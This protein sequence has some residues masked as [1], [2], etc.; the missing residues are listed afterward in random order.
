MNKDANMINGPEA[1]ET[2]DFVN[3]LDIFIENKWMIA[4]VTAIF[5][6]FGATYALVATPIY[7]T[8]ILVQVED[9]P[10]ASAAKSLL[11]NVSSLF[12]VKSS[13]AAEG[14]ILN[15]RLVV[16]R[17]VENLRLYIEAYPRRFPIL[18]TWIASRNS[19]LQHPGVFGIGGFAWGQESIDVTVFD[20]PPKLEGKKFRLKVVDPMHF[21]L[22]GD[23]LTRDFKGTVG[24]YERTES[25]DGPIVLQVKTLNGNA[26]TE[27]ELIRKSKFKTI[28]DFRK[29]LD[30]QER[31]K[32]SGVLIATLQGPD[33]VA[34]STQLNEIGHQ[35]VRQ[36]VERKSEEAAQSLEFL[37][38][39]LPAIKIRLENAQ[40]RYTQMRDRRGSV[41][42]TEEAKLA[43][44]QS[45]DYQTRL[46]QLKQEKAELATRFAP[47]YPGIQSLDTQIAQLESYGDQVT[48]QVKRLPDV[49]Q[50]VVRTMLDV[51][52]STDLYTSL[53]NNA[54]QLQLIKAGKV[55]SVRLVDT[56]SVP[57]DPVKP[58]KAVFV[59]AALFAGLLVSITIAFVRNLLFKG[60]ADPNEIERRVGLSVYATVPYSAAQRELVKKLKRNVGETSLLT[61]DHPTEPAIESLRSLRTAFQFSLLQSKNNVVLFTGPAPGI[62]KSFISANFAAI[63]AASGKKVLVID[64]DMRKGHLHQYFGIPR[65]TGLSELISGAIPIERAIN[66]NVV[67]NLD[68]IPTGILPPNPAEL[69]LNDRLK[70]LLKVFSK[71]YDVVLIDS[72]P[73]LAAADACILAPLAG[74]VFLVALANVT[75]IGEISESL[76]RL[77][78]NGVQSNGLVFNGVSPNS[79]KY[80]YGYKYGAYRYTTYEYEA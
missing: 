12:D 50:D 58:K 71:D 34:V 3:I 16:T 51:Q 36:N 56:A 60:V 35:Y 69:L 23:G 25:E 24:Q 67:E 28:E 73:I 45:A 46:L 64:G 14:Q 61:T 44:T 37:N 41:D 63:L 1:D 75:R 76:K 5:L 9:G 2:L 38:T 40:L 47:T 80:G 65:D 53:L 26:N 7:E 31:V 11:G 62:G 13:A 77:T 79:G 39:E 18:G 78:L 22:S 72:P 68:M 4:I 29:N 54:E 27:F 66:K 57:E 30:V 32:E 49:Q 8:D 43:L 19:G 42:L 6:L 55:G 33:P 15:S 59:A 52:V 70:E 17:T 20:V 21:I 10:D 74:M 48:K